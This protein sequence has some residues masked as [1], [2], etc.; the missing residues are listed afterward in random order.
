MR[1]SSYGLKTGVFLKALAQQL[2]PW[3]AYRSVPSSVLPRS[4]RGWV[5]DRGSLTQRLIDISEGHFRVRVTRQHWAM[6]AVDEAKT[7]AIPFRQHALIREVELCVSG[8]PLVRAHSVIPVETLS[9]E[10]RQLQHLGEK[11]LGAFL[12]ASRSMHRGALELARFTNAQGELCFARRSV[13]RL[14]NKPLLVSE[15]FLPEL[16]RYTAV[17]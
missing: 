15:M 2:S 16:L 5:L 10:E 6:P 13:F 4:W 1:A 7:L 11:P 9:G 3:R 8:I 17:E 14:H 12:F